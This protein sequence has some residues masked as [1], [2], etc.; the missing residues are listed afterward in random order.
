MARISRI[1]LTAVCLITTIVSSTTALSGAFDA[2]QVLGLL[3]RDDA[4]CLNSTFT[5]CSGANFPGN[6]CC[7]SSDTC[8]VIN[9]GKS[10]LCCPA[11]KDCSAVGTINCDLQQ[12]NASAH[13]TTQLFTTDLATPLEKCG[14]LCC[15]GGMTCV[16]NKQCRL[17]SPGSSSSSSA[18]SSTSRP[19]STT[20]STTTSSSSTSS[21]SSTPNTSTSATSNA[22]TKQG[23]ITST[24]CNQFPTPGVLVGFFSGLV[25]GISI[26]VFCICCIGRA[27]SNKSRDSADLSSIQ[28]TV[29][30]PIYNPDSSNSY[31]SDFLRRGSGPKVG[32]RFSRASS[33][34]RSFF[35]RTPTLGSKMS[36]SDRTIPEMPR[37]PSMK[38]E[39]SMESIRIYSPP[40]MAS[41]RPGTTNTTFGEMMA[42][43][44]LKEGQPYLGSPGRVDPRSRRIGDV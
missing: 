44:G 42:D 15:P 21:T 13:P 5:K 37:T 31:R 2:A 1:T 29:S 34:A 24:H 32:H 10:A 38:R 28:A 6:F 30:D 23:Q 43:A 9:D 35:S 39:P 17:S 19:T 11:D 22:P 12:Q 8:M 20:S 36:P 41:Q 18:A 40:N 26:T 7:R 27:R 3:P 16:D 4:T 14:D 25:A 33:R